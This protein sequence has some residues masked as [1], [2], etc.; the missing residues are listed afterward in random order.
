MIEVERR[1]IM[2]AIG[3]RSLRPAPVLVCLLAAGLLLQGCCGAFQQPA[4]QAPPTEEPAPGYQVRLKDNNA[5][6]TLMQLENLDPLTGGNWKGLVKH[7][8]VQTDSKGQAEL[9]PDGSVV[10]GTGECQPAAC[11]VYVYENSMI[12]FDHYCCPRDEAGTDFCSCS[13]TQ[14]FDECTFE[15]RTLSA[16]LRGTGTSF[17]VTYDWQ[18][19]ATVVT[20]EEGSVTITPVTSLKLEGSPAKP[21]TGDV[22]GMRQWLDGLKV[23]E[24]TLGE[25]VRVEAVP[26]GTPRQFLYTAPDAKLAALQAESQGLPAA[27]VAQ[28]LEK[29]PALVLPLRKLDPQLDP[30]L[31]RMGPA[32][33]GEIL[34]G[35]SPQILVPGEGL[36]VKI[37]AAG[38]ADTKVL[39]ALTAAVDWQSLNKTAFNADLPAVV[40]RSAVGGAEIRTIEKVPAVGYS[41]ETARTLFRESGSKTAVVIVVPD[42]RLQEAAQ[43]VQKQL[44]EVG[45]KSRVVNVSAGSESSAIRSAVDEGSAVIQLSIGER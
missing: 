20:V 19:Q 34:P 36:N 39:D 18:T 10:P 1:A 6:A 8:F 32:K 5:W 33:P 26:E 45:V 38:Q 41:P 43:Y 29:L 22:Q 23:Q 16:D 14:R 37:L 17:T 40:N 44:A 21:P 30:W 42:A 12:G 35:L 31:E 13:G 3:R 15:V 28:P 4:S 2:G 25:P 7:G 11:H 9:C 24:R 27:R